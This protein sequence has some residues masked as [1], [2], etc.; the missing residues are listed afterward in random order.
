MLNKLLRSIGIGSARIDTVLKDSTVV[1]GSYLRGEVRIT[2]G[3]TQL[4][5]S[6]ASTWHL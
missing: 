6:N 5:K 2:G 4:R 1:P 3:K